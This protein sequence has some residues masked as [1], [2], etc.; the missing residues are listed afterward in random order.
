MRRVAGSDHASTQGD[1]MSIE[2]SEER[3]VRY[4][5]FGS[6]WIQGAMRIARPYAL[7]LEYTREMLMPLLLGEDGQLPGRVLVIGLGAGSLVKYL[8]RHC[9]R[10]LITVVETNDQVLDA[11]RA[12]FQLPDD[13]ARL[14]IDIAEGSAY[15]ATTSARFDLILVDGYDARGRVG[16]LDSLAFY[17]HCRARLKPRGMVAT[18]LVSGR[19]G[20]KPSVDRMRVAFDDCAVGL[21]PCRSGNASVLASQRPVSLAMSDLRDRAAALKAATGL[22]LQPAL[23]RFAHHAGHPKTFALG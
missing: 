18:N 19:R 8:Y 4:L 23:S 6:R 3:G 17:R 7:E 10:A 21:P 2:V 13:P 22:D 14:R 12:Y 5:H 11:A 9:E 15:V 16:A 20:V 1:A